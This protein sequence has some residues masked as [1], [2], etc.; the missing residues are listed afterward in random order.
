MSREIKLTPLIFTELIYII[1]NFILLKRRENTPSIF[2]QLITHVQWIQ[3]FSPAENKF[4]WY[5]YSHK[6]A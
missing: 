2:N 4:C 1:L 3:L 6:F 5:N